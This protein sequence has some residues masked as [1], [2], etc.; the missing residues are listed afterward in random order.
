M[1]RTS[2]IA[3][4]TL[5]VATMA[6]AG[7]CARSAAA[8]GDPAATPAGG[9]PGSQGGVPRV[10]TVR[11]ALDSAG[12]VGKSVRVE[13]RCLRLGA[14]VAFG[15]P[16][17]T[18]SDWELGGDGRAIYVVGPRPPG[19][20]TDADAQSTTI[21]E[22]TVRSDTLPPRGTRAATPRRYLATG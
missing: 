13:G 3:G 22:A 21:I 10:L 15:P 11:Q 16:P 2:A 20:P 1:S 17:V 14:A 18:R 4:L 5:I 8:G 19:C 7:G 12:L 6:I 9:T